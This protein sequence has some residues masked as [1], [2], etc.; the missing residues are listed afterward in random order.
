MIQKSRLEHF[1]I[2]FFATVM[3]LTGLSIAYQKA[4]HLLN[5]P[6]IIFELLL[7]SSSIIFIYLI[8][9]Y[10]LKFIKFPD[11]VK[12][13]FF[14]PIRINFFA[15]VSISFLLLSIGYYSYFPIISVT[16]FFIGL[17][18]HTFMTFYVISFWIRHNFEINHTNPAWFIPI[19][20]NVLIPIVGVDMLC[21]E[22]SIFYFSI[23]LFFWIVLFTI[24]LYRI[25][26]HNQLPIKFIPTLFILIA[27]PAVGFIS[28]IKITTSYDFG[29]GLLYSVG[30][31]FTLLITF[32]FK[33]FLKI[34]F[35]ISWWAFTFPMAAITIANMVAYQI[36]RCEIYKFFSYIL[37]FTTTAII[38]VVAY[39]TIKHIKKEEICIEE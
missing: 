6:K 31:F 15:A 1:P 27:P 34:K 35:F 26:F 29:A 22:I 39:Q 5:F 16:L 11:Q 2:A 9:T 3:G 36:T 28:Y 19:V 37:L 21:V 14:H 32:M 17:I 8:L 20:G 23:G 12:I 25:I 24:V 30:M 13:D 38:M 4:Y 7:F 18:L 33:S 10:G